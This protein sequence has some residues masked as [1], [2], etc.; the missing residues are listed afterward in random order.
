MKHAIIL[1]GADRYDGR[2]H[3]HPATSQRIAEILREVGFDARIRACHPRAFGDL[4]A[5]DLLIVNTA[6]GPPAPEDASDDDW[7][8]AHAALRGYVE[9]GGPLLALHLAASSFREIPE[10]PHW[11]GGAWIKGTSM[12]PP[13]ADSHVTVR[14]DAHPIVA[15]LGNF[16]I[17]DE[18]YS[19]LELQPGN[20][21]LATHLYEGRDHSLA[22]AR[23]IDGRR[24]IYDAF[25]HGVRAYDSPERIRLLQREA[26]WVVGG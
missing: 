9:G 25:G 1:S 5:A 19:Y 21:V 2:W 4:A 16:T 6:S 14:T 24:A 23:E 11:I 12:H 17:Y 15:G 7:A 3:D 10:W 13:I 20:V 18:M 8:P 26:V 22:W